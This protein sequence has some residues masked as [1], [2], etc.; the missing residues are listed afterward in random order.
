M[1]APTEA[2]QFLNLSI[3][4]QKSS[5]TASQRI[6]LP[7]NRNVTVTWLTVA[8]NNTASAHRP[9]LQDKWGSFAGN[10]PTFPHTRWVH[11]SPASHM[12]PTE[13]TRKCVRQRVSFP[14]VCGSC[15]TFIAYHLVCFEGKNQCT[16]QAGWLAGHF[17]A[18]LF[19]I[20]V[21]N[22]SSFCF[23]QEGSASLPISGDLL[24]LQASSSPMIKVYCN[25]VHHSPYDAR[26]VA[27]ASRFT[28]RLGPG[29]IGTYAAVIPH[30]YGSI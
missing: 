5:Q 21:L 10:A 13:P 22:N 6:T 1:V 26:S 4:E 27:I 25:N 7:V 29:T 8:F 16:L 18:G 15:K 20:E 17:G 30:G 12:I 2:A 3:T 9:K 28:G 14:A 11:V 19:S 24:Q 23:E